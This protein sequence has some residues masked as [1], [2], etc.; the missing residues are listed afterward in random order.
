M[1]HFIEGPQSDELE[2]IK[3]DV[4][5]ID[6]DM[7]EFDTCIKEGIDDRNGFENDLPF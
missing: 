2:T 1:D 7:E 3:E 4:D 6:F 5:F